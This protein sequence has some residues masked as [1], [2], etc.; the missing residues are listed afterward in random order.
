MHRKWWTLLIVCV[1][2]F[3]LLLDITIV[4]VALPTIARDLKANFSDLQWVVD[5]Y[6]L[7]LAAV[8]LTAG[9]L[10]DL[11]GRRLVFVVGVGLFSGASLLCALAPDALFLNL[12]RGLEGIGG[13]MMYATA[14]ALLAQEFHGPERGTAFGI[15]GAAIA[16]SAAVGPLLGG[17][18]TDS[19]GWASIFYINVPVGAVVV[20]LSFLRLSESRDP[21][22]KRVDWVGTV[23]FTGALFALVLALIRGN[24]EGWTSA[25]ILGLFAASVVLMAAFLVSQAV[26]ERGMLDLRLFAK[27]AFSGASITA[28]TLAAGMFAMLLYLTLY[29]Q[30]LM[31]YSPLQTGLRFLPFTVVSFFAAAITGRLSQRFPA[32]VLLFIGLALAGAGLVLMRAVTPYSSWTVFLPGLIIGGAGVGMVNPILAFAAVGVVS[33]QRSGMATGINNTFRQ[34]GTATGIAALG[35]IFQS[36]LTRHLTTELVHTPAAGRVAEISRAVTAGRAQQ[37]IGA[38]PHADRARA[39]AAIHVAFTAALNDLLLVGGVV[40]FVGAGLALL[41]VRR[42]DFVTYAPQETAAQEAAAVPAS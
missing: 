16:A 29:I 28:F 6:A 39:S 4:N 23:T 8:L 9:A 21:E 37:V 42:R 36:T 1:A 20:L 26:Q 10:A 15:W 32:R 22:G 14:L 18:L 35:A 24:D 40:A 31:G 7:T 27:P 41:L 13:A 38:V 5:A 3:M 25:F 12:A 34:V 19:F 11:L 30:T 17:A 2:T 33:P